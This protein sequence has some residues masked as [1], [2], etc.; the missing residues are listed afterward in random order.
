M[1]RAIVWF[2][3]NGVAANL[4]LLVIVV[5]GAF[6]LTTL[7]QEVFPEASSDM[8][9][10]MIAYPGAS[11]EEVEDGLVIRVEERI[12][13]LQGVE[14]ITS[15]ASEGMATITIEA[16]EGT[17]PRQLL[18]D[19]KA[20]V[21]A[22]DTFP[23][24]AEQPVVV[25]VILRRQVINVAISGDTDEATLR[26]LG[27]RVRDDLSAIP[28]VTQV[29]LTAVRPYEL[30]IEISEA[31][32]R[33]YGLTFD[34]VANAIRRSSL[35]LPAGAIKT[36]GGEV[37][38]RTN[39][40][41]YTGAEF[42]QIVV[43][44]RPDGSRVHVGD[45]AR[46]VDGFAET[47]QSARFDGKPAVLVQ[48]FRVGEQN[49]ITVA[50]HVKEYVAEAEA[51]L[52]EGIALTTWQDDTELLKSRRDL[53]LR[54]GRVGLLL[55][56]LV[57]ALFLRLRIA[58][59][60][61]IGIPV[62]FLG[63]I[64]LLPT[65]EISINLLSLFAFIIVLGIV[66]DDAIV[67]GENIHTHIERGKPALQASIDGAK[68]VAVPVVFSILTTVAAFSPLLMV[69]GTTGRFMRA[70][71]IIVIATLFFSLLESLFVL[72][73]HLSHL[74][75]ETVRE[76]L[77]GSWTRLRGK[78]SSVLDRVISRA[79]KP[80]LHRALEWRYSV[81]AG[82]LSLLILTGAAIGTGWI[83]FTFFPPVEADN[84]VVF[85]TMPLGTP[86]EQTAATMRRLEESAERLR[87]ELD[88]E[89]QKG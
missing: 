14:R 88:L 18:D 44:S 13:D 45:V 50:A 58:A 37:L 30:S 43:V 57:L 39:A 80:S 87:I 26:R 23:V 59:W 64:W 46:V 11:P 27:E 71:P 86:V 89:G 9:S 10:V 76:G 3:K 20:R 1:N 54:N 40:Q 35:D 79:Y 19:V 84:V 29:E 8:I 31:S 36:A 7:K 22:I 60:V 49:A 51:R 32:L 78:F 38:I 61:A 6:T 68:E 24:D 69:G 15:S 70:I 4:L 75:R 63:A 66:V 56:F 41:A 17:D 5:G 33:R 82:A 67:V 2:A 85:V 48:V 73:S 28:G 42:E 77:A 65:F 53:L 81:V 72:P 74:K 21:D 55:L 62:S 34:A 16:L 25:E 52:P 47:D 83:K 12:Q